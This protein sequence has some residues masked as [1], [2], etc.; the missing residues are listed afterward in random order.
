MLLL[1][2]LLPLLLLGVPL[3][4]LLLLGGQLLPAQALLQPQA[5][6]RG[7]AVLAPPAPLALQLL[8]QGRRLVLPMRRWVRA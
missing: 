1:L 8:Q 7:A 5:R 3:L 4:P 2:P 6:R